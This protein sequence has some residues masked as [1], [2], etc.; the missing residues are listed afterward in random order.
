[1]CMS[2]HLSICVMLL[3][4]LT[5]FSRIS[6]VIKDLPVMCMAHGER[7]IIIVMYQTEYGEHKL[8]EQT[9]SHTG[10]SAHLHDWTIPWSLV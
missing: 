8:D 3:N 9:D 6:C 7:T 5:V 2:V 1:M 4:R 10:H